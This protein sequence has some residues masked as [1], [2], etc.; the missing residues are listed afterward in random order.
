MISTIFGTFFGTFCQNRPKIS[1]IFVVDQMAY[2][3]IPKLGANFKYG[4]RTLLDNGIVYTNA[5]HPHGMP[6]TATGHTALSTGAF[7]K[8][9]GIIGNRWVDAKGKKIVSDYDTPERAA[10]FAP[11]GFYDDAASPRQIMVDGLSDQFAMSSEPSTPRRAISVSLKSRAAVATAGKVGKAIWLDGKTGNFTSSKAYY[12][13][14]PSWISTFNSKHNPALKKSITWKSFYPLNS[15]MYNFADINFIKKPRLVGTTISLDPIKEENFD[16]FDKTPQ[17][18]QLVL[19]MA[20]MAFNEF[21]QKDESELLLWVCLSSLDKLG[22]EYGSNS[23]EIIDML[24]HLDKQIQN[25][26][27]YVLENTESES[28]VL[29]AWTA[30]HGVSP[31]IELVKDKGYTAARRIKSS[32]IKKGMNTLIAQKYGTQDIVMR[33]KSPNFYL[34]EEKLNKFDKQTRRSIL[35]D[36][37]QYL[38]SHEGI[39]NAWTYEELSHATFTKNQKENFYK[40]QLYPGRSGQIIFQTYPYNMV[41]KWDSGTDHRTPYNYDIHVPLVIYQPGVLEHKVINQNVWTLQFANTLADIL[42]IQRPS[43]SIQNKLPGVE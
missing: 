36:L 5:Y 11:H 34:D 39:K 30:D 7:A 38:L 24:Y 4:F 40:Q 31:V 43:A 21:T 35:H 27:D 22:H 9:H 10:I 23:L 18:N 14:I 26:M 41:T 28:D 6:A 19:D 3:Y 16:L 20:K 32:E 25:F 12:D 1:V 29:F 33:V 17:A 13:S 8:D 15:N 2:S 37:K 42:D